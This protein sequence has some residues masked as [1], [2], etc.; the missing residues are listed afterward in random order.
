MASMRGKFRRT[1]RLLFYAAVRL[2]GVLATILP[3]RAALAAFAGIGCVVRSVD[4]AAVRRSRAHL[5]KALAR[6][7]PPAARERILREMF[8][9]FGR[10]LVDLLG[11][12]PLGAG[13]LQVDGVEHLERAVRRGRGVV[14]LSGHLGNWEVLGAAVAA[15]GVPLHV[16]AARL[17]DRRSDRLLTEWRSARGI[18]VHDRSEGLGPFL[19]A[20][21]RGEIVGALA[22]QDA[23]GRAMFVDFFRQPA[24]TPVAPFVLAVRTRAAIVPL[25]IHLDGDGRHRIVVRPEIVPDGRLRG[26]ARLRDLVS[27]WHAVLEAEIRAHPE[28][29]VWFH[30]RWKSAPSP[31]AD[32]REFSKEP[33]YLATFQGSRRRVFAR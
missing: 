22:D 20:L 17:F 16:L 18:R 21:R 6:E 2:F 30:R 4:R 27:R 3:R 7:I 29:W 9:A 12:R 1:K 32:F 10:N 5:A 28:Q 23:P 24:R 19:A 25:F 15:R 26:P 8:P 14:A 13:D 11:S 31:L 33:A